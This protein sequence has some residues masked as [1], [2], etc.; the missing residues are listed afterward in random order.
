MKRTN[1]HSLVNKVL[2][3]FSLFGFAFN[4][5]KRG[6]DHL[7]SIKSSITRFHTYLDVIATKLSRKIKP[8]MMVSLSAKRENSNLTGQL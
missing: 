3:V 8:L 5:F 7:K 4:K 6:V 2:I 1:K